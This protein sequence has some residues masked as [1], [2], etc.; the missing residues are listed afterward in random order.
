MA[1]SGGLGVI[2][3]ITVSAALTA[4]AN[5]EKVEFPKFQRGLKEI[6]AHD[7]TGGWAEYLSTGKRE[8]GSFG[9][10]LTWDK[11]EATHA[12]ILTAFNAETPV[13]MSIQDPK[14]AEIIAFSAF[15]KTID[16]VS[17]LETAYQCKVE[18]Q[19]TGVPAITP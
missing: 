7:S 14:G 19:P 4:I 2:V 3:K 9:M 11:A 8:L 15:I 17:D 5:V 1:V 16:R 10:T 13:N 18:V 12:A 6:T